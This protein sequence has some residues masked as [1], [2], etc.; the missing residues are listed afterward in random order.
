[1]DHKLTE[2]T[3]EQFYT[4]KSR[5]HNLHYGECDYYD[6][7]GFLIKEYNGYYVAYDLS[8][9]Y[10]SGSTSFPR[11]YS[12]MTAKIDNEVRSRE[13]ASDLLSGAALYNN[14]EPW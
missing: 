7:R 10:S 1:M 14:P 8:E 4:H 11:Y 5:P 3:R 6:Y 12:E 2:L 13:A 9:Y